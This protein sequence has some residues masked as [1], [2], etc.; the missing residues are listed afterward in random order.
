M[1]N[2]RVSGA[3]AQDVARRRRLPRV[4]LRKVRQGW[5]PAP[6]VIGFLIAIGFGGELT[7]AISGAGG[8]AW[9]A[10]ALLLIVM[11][12]RNR[13]DMTSAKQFAAIFLPW[14]A[15][16]LIAALYTLNPENIADVARQFFIVAIG[17]AVHTAARRESQRHEIQKT[18]LVAAIVTGII[19][20][21][22][23]RPLVENGWS[24]EAVRATKNQLIETSGFGAN[25][26]CFAGLVAA[27]AAYR[28]ERWRVLSLF[29]IILFVLLSIALAA[30][31]PM[32]LLAVAGLIS[33]PLSRMKWS[34]LLSRTDVS[35]VAA[36]I[37][38]MVTVGSFLLSVD[39]IARSTLADQLAG[40]SALWQIGL[41]GWAD[42]PVLGNGLHSYARVLSVHLGQGT[43]RTAFE[44]RALYTL[45]GGAFHNIWVTVLVERGLLG[46]LGLYLSYS[47]L[48]RRLLLNLKFLTPQGRF[49][50]LAIIMLLFLR[51][52]VEITG[53]M[54]YGNSAL[55]AI[56][57]IAL[58]LMLAPPARRRSRSAGWGGMATKYAS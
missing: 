45:N 42:A 27:C 49:Q 14:L 33:W 19:S 44:M 15:S 22:V 21:L 57:I 35:F 12:W 43:F 25:T 50:A 39:C 46:M 9:R 37:F 40:R 24:W 58:A 11:A 55:D 29:L 34:G 30:R 2:E 28:T 36:A 13:L 31:A 4:H 10:G 47:L 51:G 1:I 48:I 53:L 6:I 56:V 20:I 8:V 16:S 32:L 3:P 38:L 52:F 17:A 7:E 5:G 26:V 23:A 18:L 54:S 41:S